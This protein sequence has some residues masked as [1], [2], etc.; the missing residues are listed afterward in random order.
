MINEQQ[1]VDRLAAELYEYGKLN[2]HLESV[3]AI[4]ALGNKD[5]RLASRA[6]GLWHQGLAPVIVASGGVG[7]LTPKEWNK[8][9]AAMSAG[10]LYESGVP[11]DKVIV[12]DQSTNLPK[13]IEFSIAAL[14]QR[15]LKAERLILS[16]LPFAERRILGQCRKQ[17]PRHKFLLTSPKMTYS[18]YPNSFIDRNETINLIAG[19]LDRLI[20]FPAAG[21]SVPETV[22]Q[23]IQN[24][25][26]KLFEAGYD[27][28]EFKS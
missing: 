16:V 28:Y 20:K 7:R 8:P 5:L 21:F 27:K 3:D 11:T 15:G 26:Q 19:E 2:Q 4:L 18:S 25:V 23:K 9:E 22:P 24:A 12:E 14:H 6:A 1:D 17:F 10:K 13:N